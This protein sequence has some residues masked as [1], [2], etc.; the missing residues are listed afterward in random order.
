MDDFGGEKLHDFLQ[1]IA[2]EVDAALIW[3]EDHL[4]GAPSSLDPGGIV[5]G[6]SQKRI[7]G[8]RRLDMARHVNFRDDSDSAAAGKIQDLPDILFGVV[9]AIRDV[10]HHR[11]N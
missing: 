8:N 1:H 10:V 7:G 3:I 5:R 4:S 9:S 6:A 2:E 11:R